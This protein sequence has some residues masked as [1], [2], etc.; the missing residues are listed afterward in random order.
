MLSGLAGGLLLVVA[1]G[2]GGSSAPQASPGGSLA[3]PTSAAPASAA[4]P[5]AATSCSDQAATDGAQISME[6]THTLNPSDATIS[7]GQSV[8]WTNNSPNANHQIVFAAGPACNITL[9]RKAVSIKFDTPGKYSYVCKLHPDFM[10]G[11][12]TVQ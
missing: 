10:K 1:V 8:T 3:A 2:C 11:T 6:G 9:I 12:I 5:V 7:A 4:G